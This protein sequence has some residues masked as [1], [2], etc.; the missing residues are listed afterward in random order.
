[1]TN[2]IQEQIIREGYK[3]AEKFFGSIEKPKGYPLV[4]DYKNVEEIRRG[5]RTL[6][7]SPSFERTIRE[8]YK[9]DI[10]TSAGKAISDWRARVDLSKAYGLKGSNCLG[11]GL[12]PGGLSGNERVEEIADI[13]VANDLGHHTSI[14]LGYVMG[15]ERLSQHWRNTSS[16]GKLSPL[17]LAKGIYLI[18]HF[19]KDQEEMVQF[20]RERIR[21][22]NY[23][24]NGL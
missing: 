24:L 19:G 1:M 16:L 22:H 12:R 21:K 9:G 14:N 11:L 17:F 23:W 4:H 20:A 15:D 13:L 6:D 2:E 8:F 7:M 3:L 18:N 10:I 5:N